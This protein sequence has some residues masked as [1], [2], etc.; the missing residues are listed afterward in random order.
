M[1]SI[2]HILHH[3]QPIKHTS[4]NPLVEI[5]IRKGEEIELHPPQFASEMICQDCGG[6]ESC[7]PLQNGKRAWF[8]GAPNCVRTDS[9]ITKGRARKKWLA[10]LQQI[11]KKAEQRKT[12]KEWNGQ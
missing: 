1:K 3:H 4:D 5:L 9:Q 10:E 6:S 11:A 12:N 2:K 8:C 7:T